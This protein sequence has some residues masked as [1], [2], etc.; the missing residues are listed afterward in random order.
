MILHIHVQILSVFPLSSIMGCSYDLR[1][2][3]A[4]SGTA[5]SAKE[6]YFKMLHVNKNNFPICTFHKWTCAN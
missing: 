5:V 6:I 1:I 3:S 4:S 2:C